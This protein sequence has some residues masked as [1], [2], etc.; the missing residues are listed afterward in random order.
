MKQVNKD[1]ADKQIVA[2][3][4]SGFFH[5]PSNTITYL[6]TDPATL[7]SV[8]IDPVLDYDPK[9]ARTCTNSADALL[10]VIEK[11]RLSVDL[12]LETHIHADH[13]S[14]AD[15]LKSR[16]GAKICVS[17]QIAKVQKTFDPL[18]N[19][20]Y[21]FA[22]DGRQFDQLL[23]NGD[24]F[25]I[26]KLEARVMA[27]PGHTPAC[28]SFHI[29]DAVFVGD[30][31]FRPDFGTARCDFP[32]GDAATLYDSIE[33]ILSL[34]DSTRLFLCHDYPAQGQAPTYETT[35]GEQ[36]RHN[37]HYAGKSKSEFAKL[38][39]DRDAQLDMPELI[40]PAIQLNM[41]AG[42]LPPVEENGTA[43]LKIPL[44]AV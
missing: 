1:I 10:E 21:P 43:Y 23:K 11:Q 17:S 8:I 6:V 2:P 4:V 13:L 22:T 41:Q 27:T 40:L 28:L 7:A 26:G 38:R 32:G 35:V 20:P 3:A 15:Y 37:I 18:F 44:N 5:E 42:A 30:T 12:I 34:P 31:L 33:N 19:L 9:A 25:Q 16:L 14:A 24:T 29:H 36:K 39:H